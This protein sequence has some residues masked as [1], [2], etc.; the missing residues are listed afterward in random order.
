PLDS[1]RLCNLSATHRD[2]SPSPTRRSSDLR[3]RRLRKLPASERCADAWLASR[4]SSKFHTWVGANSKSLVK[5]GCSAAL[6]AAALSITRS[7]E[8]T[9]ELQSHL[10]FVCRLL[11]VRQK[12]FY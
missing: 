10:N 6:L 8:H 12:S 4:G 1:P 7:E 5:A 2:L 11:L 3:A 9:S